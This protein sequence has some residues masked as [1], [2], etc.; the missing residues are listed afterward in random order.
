M[1]IDYNVW[2]KKWLK[3]GISLLSIKI[4]NIKNKLSNWKLS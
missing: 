1:L 2:N 4:L 3:G